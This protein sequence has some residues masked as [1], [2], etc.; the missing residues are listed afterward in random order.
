ML[1]LLILLAPVLLFLY[2][3]WLIVKAAAILFI[4]LLQVLFPAREERTIGTLDPITDKVK[5]D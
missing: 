4:A 5:W 3:A 1:W 2:V